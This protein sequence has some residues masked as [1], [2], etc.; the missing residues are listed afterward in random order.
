MV[1]VGLNSYSQLDPVGSNK[2]TIHAV[3]LQSLR[4]LG[5][6]T[7][8]YYALG[9]GYKGLPIYNK[10]IGGIGSRF[11]LSPRLNLFAQVGFGSGGYAQSLVDMGSDLLGYPKVSAE[12]MVTDCMGVAVIAGYLIAPDG[13]SK[14]V[15][16]GLALNSHFGAAAKSESTNKRDEGEYRG[17]RLSA[18]NETKISTTFRGVKRSQVNL[19]NVQFDR[20]FKENFYMP[21]CG[22]IALEA[23]RGYPGYGEVSV[24][25]GTQSKYRETN[26]FQ[27]FAELQAGANV[28]G[29]IVRAGVGMIYSLTDDIGLRGVASQTMGSE[30]F[31]STNL[32]LGITY[33]FSTARF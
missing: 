32:E 14:N 24:G 2:G 19:M 29:P 15:T 11:E 25:L 13:T 27:Y 26:P 28:E 10:V 23:Y 7:D 5:E 6:K 17:Y 4:F 1:S 12:Y 16:F 33:R 8:L 22:S 21:I 30:R 9:V 3:D 31:R 18:S 20:M